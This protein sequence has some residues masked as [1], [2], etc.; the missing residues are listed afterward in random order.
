MRLL[1]TLTGREIEKGTCRVATGVQ[2]PNR[3]I[4]SLQCPS[5]IPSR[6]ARQQPRHWIHISEG[7]KSGRRP[8]SVL[9]AVLD[10][11]DDLKYAVQA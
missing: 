6:W 11:R 3:R 10:L 4:A 5:R 7:G 9:V 8:S 2:E 1:V